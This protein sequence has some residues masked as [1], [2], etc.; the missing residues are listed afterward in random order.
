MVI[1]E[2]CETGEVSSALHIFPTNRH[3]NEHNVQQLFKSCPEYVQI[4]AQDYF[5]DLKTGR[6]KLKTWHHGGVY[7]TCL[8]EKLLLGKDAR[9]MLCKNIDIAD[10]LVNGVCGTVTRIV[11]S[12]TGNF[13]PKVFV[14]FDDDVVGQ[15]R[16]KQAVGVFPE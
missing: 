7:S 9:V 11:R 15:Q 10:G 3:V 12:E 2:R 5:N 4:D 16:R 13:P 8:E 1:L 6:L 14:K